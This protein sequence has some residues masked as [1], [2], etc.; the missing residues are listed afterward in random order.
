MLVYASLTAF[1]K[2]RGEGLPTQHCKIEMAKHGSK[3]SAEGIQTIKLASVSR[4]A[5]KLIAP[6]EPRQAPLC[7]MVC[8]CEYVCL[9]LN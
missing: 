3:H 8:E 6:S 2:R 9:C 1:I 4:I 5:G 7:L